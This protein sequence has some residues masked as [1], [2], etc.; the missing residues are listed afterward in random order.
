MNEM[1]MIG[2]TNFPADIQVAVRTLTIGGFTLEKA[3]RNP[4]FALIYT[5]RYDEFGV[6]QQYCFAIFDNPPSENEIV[7]AE[8]A[9]RHNEYELVVISPSE[10]KD[11]ASIEWVRFLNL[12]GGPVFS[13]SPLDKE[14]ADHLM[15]LGMHKIP[16]GLEGKADDLFELYVHRALEF[17]FGCRVN[18]YVGISQ[19]I[20]STGAT[21]PVGWIIGNCRSNI[22]QWV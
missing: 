20:S 4:T 7:S 13:Y 3:T 14:F 5:Y 11:R 1:E 16:D 8:I 19:S 21:I 15:K 18:T 10:I 6:K 17:I 22:R 9:A 2:I 12:F